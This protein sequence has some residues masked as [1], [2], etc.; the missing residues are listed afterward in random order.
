M[1]NISSMTDEQLA[2][3]L[4]I[5]VMG[6]KKYCNFEGRECFKNDDDWHW[7]EDWQPCTD[8]NQA[9]ECAENWQGQS[10]CRYVVIQRQAYDAPPSLV[11]LWEC[12]LVDI[13][14]DFRTL[15]ESPARA[16]CEAVLMAVRG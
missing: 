14:N 4:A 1:T 8:L 3:A 11:D 9:V 15:N 2:E 16:L 6:W 13:E 10:S 12:K 5:E 7:I